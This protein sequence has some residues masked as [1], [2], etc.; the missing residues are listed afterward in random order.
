MALLKGKFLVSVSNGSKINNQSPSLRVRLAEGKQTIALLRFPRSNML[1][2]IANNPGCKERA[3]LM[4]Q[5]V[6][7]GYHYQ[8]VLE[9]LAK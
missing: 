8:D 6:S 7:Q 5:M 4:Q 1:A 9:I 3:E 2:Y